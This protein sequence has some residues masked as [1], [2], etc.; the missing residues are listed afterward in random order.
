MADDDVRRGNM[1]SANDTLDINELAALNNDITP[2]FIEQLQSQIEQNA[3]AFVANDKGD[4]KSDSELFEEVN[5]T[6]EVTLVSEQAEEI[7]KPLVQSQDFETKEISVSEVEADIA[8][9]N[10][11]IKQINKDF[12]EIE[13]LTSGNIIEK[14]ISQEMLD[15]S[16]SLSYLDENVKY[17]KY[18]IYIDPE[19]KDFM[20]SLTVKERKNLVN[21]ILREQ[22][23][24]IIKKRK[25]N[26]ISKVIKHAIVALITIALTIPALYFL[27]NISLEASINNYRR[28]QMIFQTLYKEK[29]KIQ[30]SKY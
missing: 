28:S 13:N 17:S 24:I 26:L 14:P 15:Y 23:N 1:F 25:L 7:S 29:G 6:A 8:L 18:V 2:E 4:K 10:Q 22:D 5:I 19:N 16:N 9:L 11:E 12:E 3:N 27:I 20:D 21:N 30:Q